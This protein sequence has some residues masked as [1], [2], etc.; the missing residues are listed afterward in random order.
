MAEQT[1][2]EAWAELVEAN[3]RRRLWPKD[4]DPGPADAECWDAARALA[5]A[6]L[7]AANDKWRPSGRAPLRQLRA[8]R[9]RIGALGT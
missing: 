4:Q 6:V 3:V 7:E 9:L 1:V 5:L 8:F 2:E